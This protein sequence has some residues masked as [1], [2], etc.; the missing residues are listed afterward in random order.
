MSDGFDL[1]IPLDAIDRKVI[2]VLRRHP[3][4]SISEM[5]RL[6]GLARATVRDR[7]RR[8]EIRKVIMGYG[9]DID[10]RAAGFGVRCFTTLTIAQGSYESALQ[11]LSEVDGV[12]EINTIT[13]RGDLLVRVVATTNDE[14]HELLV[15]IMALDEVRRSETHLAVH[16]VPVRTIADLVATGALR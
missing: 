11:S 6:A 16:T 1:H 8:L 5:A 12:L 14:L 2:G 15:R 3:R 9:P 4:S 10:P 7:I 13:G